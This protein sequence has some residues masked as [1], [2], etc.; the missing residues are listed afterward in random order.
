MKQFTFK[1]RYLLIPTDDSGNRIPIEVPDDIIADQAIN[2][3]SK[4]KTVDKEIKDKLPLKAKAKHK[5]KVQ[6]SRAY[7]QTYNRNIKR[8]KS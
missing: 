7:G 4:I 2:N 6:T 5:K 1:M 3:S 8:S